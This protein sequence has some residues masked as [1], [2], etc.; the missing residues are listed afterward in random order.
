MNKLVFN[1]GKE[2]EI[3]QLDETSEFVENANRRV[4]IAQF[5]VDMDVYAALNDVMNDF[6]ACSVIKLI[7]PDTDSEDTHMGY[8]LKVELR[9]PKVDLGFDE[10]GDPKSEERIIAKLAKYTPLERAVEVWKYQ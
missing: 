4:L 1:N 9:Q 3:L 7:N 2:F 10:N 8:Q 5:A 6:G